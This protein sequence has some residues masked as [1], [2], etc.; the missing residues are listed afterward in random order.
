MD[1]FTDNFSH[2]I[3]ESAFSTVFEELSKF[4]VYSETPN[5]DLNYTSSSVI[6][7]LK[8]HI[9][10]QTC[11]DGIIAIRSLI[12]TPI[13]RATDYGFSVSEFH[14]LC[15]NQGPT[16]VLIKGENG[17]IVAGYASKSRDRKYKG[18]GNPRGFLATIKP[19][20]TG[21]E[22]V[23][24]LSKF[25]VK[26]PGLIKAEDGMLHGPLFYFRNIE[27]GFYILT[28]PDIF[29]VWRSDRTVLEIKEDQNII[30][31]EVPNGGWYTHPRVRVLLEKMKLFGMSDVNQK[32]K[33]LEYEVYKIETERKSFLG[34][35]FEIWQ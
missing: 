33:V 17:E 25:D 34:M 5:L 35:A 9:S 26:S 27:W 13:Y 28:I 4:V 19:S 1:E 18:V 6:L 31:A 10:I 14:R 16:L 7:D 30:F 20:T 8:A 32:L 15:D 29:G 2:I 24:D 21:A 11:Q 12:M 23:Y 3:D 22:T